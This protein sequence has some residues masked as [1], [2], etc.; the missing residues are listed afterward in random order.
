M[1]LSVL[2]ICPCALLVLS[3]VVNAFPAQHEV[4]GEADCTPIAG[5]TCAARFYSGWHARFPNARGLNLV[6]SLNE[7]THF[8]AFLDMNNY[9]SNRLYILLCW[10]YFPQCRVDRPDFPAV[11]PCREICLQAS[12]ACQPYANDA[13]VDLSKLQHL[14]CSNFP[15][16]QEDTSG[17]SESGST[18]SSKKYACPPPSKSKIL[19]F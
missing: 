10:H 9:C 7:F 11:V 3:C 18:E 2:H 19:L 6:E 12:E 15:S 17:D 8:R 1:S 4:H 14:N 16:I 13:D 5:S